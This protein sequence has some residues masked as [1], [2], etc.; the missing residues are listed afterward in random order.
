MLQV[1]TMSF[2]LIELKRLGMSGDLKG[3][4]IIGTKI[5]LRMKNRY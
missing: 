4:Q 2:A 1:E 3:S 5:Q